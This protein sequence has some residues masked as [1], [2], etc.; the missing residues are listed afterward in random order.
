MLLR[1]RMETEVWTAGSW[2][3]QSSCLGALA[4]T[5][6]LELAKV[7]DAAVAASSPTE[8][9]TSGRCDTGYTG[10]LCKACDTDFF[11]ISGMCLKC[12]D[13]LAARLA[14]T[15]GGGI[16]VVVAWVFLGVYMAGTFE[17]LNI[18]LLYLQIGSM[19]QSFNMDWADEISLWAIFQQIV[20]FDVDIIGPQC[21]IPAYNYG[22]SY[23]L[24][25]LLPIA[26]TLAYALPFA[27]RRHRILREVHRPLV[28]K[29][30][31][32]GDRFDQTVAHVLSFQEIVY[33]SLC[34]RCFQPLMCDSMGDELEYLSVAPD[35]RCW[36]GV[37]ISMLV[38]SILVF[39]VYVLGIPGLF[40]A[41][42]YHGLKNNL[43]TEKSFM[44]KFAWMY[45]SFELE[46]AWWG[47]LIF[48]RRVVCAAVLVF[49]ARD[50][51][52]QSILALMFLIAAIVMHFFARP[53]VVTWYD[54]MESTSLLSLSF[55]VISGLV[56]YTK[57]KHNVDVDSWTGIF[58][59][60][61]ALQ[62]GL[63]FAIFAYD[64]YLNHTAFVALKV[65]KERFAAVR[66]TYD[67]RHFLFC[68]ALEKYAQP[69]D[70]GLG[71]ADGGAG[72]TLEQFSAVLQSLEDG[73]PKEF[74]V[75]S[76]RQLFIQAELLAG[77]DHT[78][79]ANSLPAAGAECGAQRQA[80]VAH[81]Q[82]SVA[83]EFI[84]MIMRDGVRYMIASFKHLD[85]N[86]NA[87]LSLAEVK[88]CWMS[89]MPDE[90]SA[91]SK[92]LLLEGFFFALAGEDGELEKAEI[93]QGLS[94]LLSG[95]ICVA[96]MLRDA[97]NVDRR[98]GLWR[99]INDTVVALRM[100]KKRP[101]KTRKRRA[102]AFDQIGQIGSV[103]NAITASQSV[104]NRRITAASE[105]EDM[106]ASDAEPR[107]ELWDALS[108]SF[109]PS[110]MK[111]RFPFSVPQMTR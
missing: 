91:D 80:E 31:E 103:I 46:W 99:M 21:V 102:S 29:S 28:E 49:A 90:L 48:V 6:E 26:V 12:P 68:L 89:G 97:N 111:V 24:Q 53:Y 94:E 95:K 100:Q 64:V 51:F 54:I 47:M 38:T 42:L 7:A 17:S 104:A 107:S 86:S 55:T 73:Q 15:I 9:W 78:R 33:H 44:A 8:E 30:L 36:E 85:V 2:R 16:L 27:W 82:Q 40:A 32:I 10:R 66:E 71:S 63:G 101:S 81:L 41:V 45:N 4:V 13:G 50:P 5:A 65:G 52:F 105:G 70:L 59:V 35:I 62:M 76:S 84:E 106:V 74:K 58:F 77:L 39:V 75:W 18:L 37:H 109:R 93:D 1:V 88:A 20:N 60:A 43:L 96:T 79:P 61:I 56:Y 110:V 57:D 14:L 25:L 34:I 92:Q 98:D 83:V 67:R 3:G 69:Q 72:L 108:G 87:T 11:E 22:W 19:L 23:F